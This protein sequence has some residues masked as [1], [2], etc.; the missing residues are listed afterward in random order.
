MYMGY[1]LL[2]LLYLHMCLYLHILLCCMDFLHYNLFF[3]I[4]YCRCSYWFSFLKYI[5]VTM[6]YNSP[7]CVDQ[8]TFC[9]PRIIYSLIQILSSLI[10]KVFD[11]PLPPPYQHP[12]LYHCWWKE[13]ENKVSKNPC[14]DTCLRT[15]SWNNANTILI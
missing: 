13:K 4:P 5:L 8:I 11:Y 15:S 14:I 9:V 6:P 7:N 3:I 12:N 10:E 2:I 1:L